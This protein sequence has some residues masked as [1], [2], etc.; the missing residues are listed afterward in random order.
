[1]KPASRY[2]IPCREVN[3]IASSNVNSVPAIAPFRF[4]SISAWCAYVTVAP[5]DRSNT[6][7]NRGIP[8]GLR[9][10]IPAEASEYLIQL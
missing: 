1:M 4:P 8:N 10:S 5:D 9:A 7:F 2:S 3:R 6:V